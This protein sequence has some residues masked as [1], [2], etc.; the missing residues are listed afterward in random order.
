VRAPAVSLLLALC[1]VSAIAAPAQARPFRYGEIEGVANLE[2]SYGLLARVQ[3]RDEDLIAIVN[4]GDASSA[5]FD[6]GD[7]NYDQGIVS[8]ALQVSGELAARGSIFGVYL[9]G[10]SFYDFETELADRERTPLTTHA[11]SYVGSDTEL[12]EY[13]VDA[14]FLWRG[15]PVRV[16]VGDQVLSWGESTFLRF[17]VPVSNPLDL[18]AALRPVGSARDVVLP[19]GMIWA[20]ANPTENVAFEA[21]YEYDWDPARTPPVGSYFSDNNSVGSGGLGAAMLGAGRFSDL[22]TNLD[23]AFSL[24]PGTLEFDADFMRIPGYGKDEPSD[25]GQFGFTVQ[26]ILPNL[27]STKLALH[28]ARYHSRLPI[29]D[30]RTAN[31]A[32]AAA[33]SSAAVSARAAALTP[34]YEAEGLPPAEAAAAAAAAA[35]ALT[36]GEYASDASYY[37]EYPANI[38]VIGLSFNTATLQTGTLVSGEIS[39]HLGFPF[40]I[41]PS[42]VLGAA[43]SPIEFTPAFGEGPLGDYGPSEKISGVKKL[44]KTQLELGLRQLFGPRL[45]AAESFLGVDVGWVHVHRMPGNDDLRLSAPG[46]TGEADF[47]HLPT[48]D[49]W[50]YRVIGALTYEDVLGR[51]TVQPHAAWLH[52]VRGITPGPGGAFLEQRKAIN[53]GV[54]VDYLST[55]LV[56]LDYTTLF[57]ASRFNLQNDRDF[58]RFQVSYYY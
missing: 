50:G 56:Q 41:L 33:T 49:S 12:S 24:P 15:M 10:T 13:F 7:L 2:L 44:D 19:Q 39:H 23:A 57:G 17:G 29:L 30:A 37:L 38:Q 31:A 42:D 53:V 18:N 20:S 6:D 34:I 1:A 14:S 40:Q 52:D 21:Y 47:A 45:G 26:A 9:R 11:E 16:R 36:I 27:N 54:S 46:I 28:Y 32:A 55:W 43:L 51:F 4:G 58:V 48:S 35:S 3:D 25:Q 8:N 22:G 5:N